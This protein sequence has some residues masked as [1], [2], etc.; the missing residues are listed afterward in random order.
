MAVRS[1]MDLKTLRYFVYV[2]E[3]RSFS[4]AAV[5]LRI[6]QPALSRQIR[7]LEDEI[8]VP[9][10]LR[11]RRQLELT[12][13]GLLL[14][15]RAHSLLRQVGQTADDVRA[16]GTRVQGTITIGVSPTISDSLVPH[17]VRAS[18]ERHPELR[19]NF[20]EGF[21]GFIFQRLINQ[22]LTLCLMHNPPRHRSIEIEPLMTEP[23]FLVGPGAAVKDLAPARKGM[24]L[25]KVRLILPNRTHSLRMLIERAMAERGAHLD[26]AIQ[27]DGY[28]TTKALVASG[29]GYTVLPLSSVQKE[30]EEHQL[31]AAPLRKPALSWTVSVAYRKDQSAARAVSAL[32][33]IIAASV[34]M[35]R[36]DDAQRERLE[37]AAAR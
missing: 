35:L 32:R 25:D 3:A 27:V 28:T 9:L 34:K 23:L 24:R 21:S 8:G 33:E 10:V 19:L 4:K 13:A 20:V 18:A 26:V 29:L 16:H 22:E 6:A 11:T 12:D 5:Q 31:T 7:K 37:L 1:A 15:Q 17:I 2:A 36:V 14:L 30:I